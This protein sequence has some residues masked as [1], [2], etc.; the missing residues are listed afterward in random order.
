MQI[1]RGSGFIL[2]RDTIPVIL[3]FATSTELLSKKNRLLTEDVKVT[4]SICVLFNCS[5]ELM[6]ESIDPDV[7]TTIRFET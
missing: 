3:S 1:M 5:T 6:T 7:L 4:F 2:S